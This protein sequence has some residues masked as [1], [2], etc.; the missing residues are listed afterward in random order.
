MQEPRRP[1]GGS[2]TTDLECARKVRPMPGAHRGVLVLMYA[3]C[4]KASR[5]AYLQGSPCSN[6][7]IPKKGHIPTV[8]YW[9]SYATYTMCC[10]TSTVYG[11]KA[12][13]FPLNRSFCDRAAKVGF[14]NAM[15]LLAVKLEFV[16]VDS[17]RLQAVIVCE[18]TLSC[19]CPRTET[20]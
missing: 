3:N 12:L 4:L 6:H 13:R 20:P 1:W 14:S 5:E 15:R 9:G 17:W 11:Q 7:S 16:E 2:Q 10:K 19:G 8:S 18:F